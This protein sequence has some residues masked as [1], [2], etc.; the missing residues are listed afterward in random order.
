MATGLGTITVR[1]QGDGKEY[2]VSTAR[3][4]TPPGLD[5]QTASCWGTSVFP[6]GFLG[7]P[8]LFHP[9]LVSHYI[10][11]GDGWAEAVHAYI[12]AI[13]E[14]EPRTD[15]PTALDHIQ[16]ANEDNF[17]FLDVK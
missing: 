8:R 13:V 1:N 4:P 3:F 10:A 6:K 2:V 16:A 15:W 17:R 9:V 5:L 7:K 12:A 14:K 11:G